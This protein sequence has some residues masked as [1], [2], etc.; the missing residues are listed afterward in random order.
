MAL[1]ANAFLL[2][3]FLIS[4]FV[5]HLFVIFS[6]C[7]IWDESMSSVGAFSASLLLRTGATWASLAR[8]YKTLTTYYLYYYYK[9]T[10]GQY[11]VHF[12]SVSTS[13]YR[14]FLQIAARTGD[15]GEGRR[16]VVQEA[17]STRLF[18]RQQGICKTLFLGPS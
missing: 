8:L 1:L 15:S 6:F 16:E 11:G 12:V 17:P 5:F 14:S 10:L 13:I 4:S 2:H 18:R 3:L 7:F 9:Y